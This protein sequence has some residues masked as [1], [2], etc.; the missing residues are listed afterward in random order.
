MRKPLGPGVIRADT[1]V[2]GQLH[3]ELHHAMAQIDDPRRRCSF[4]R[5]CAEKYIILHRPDL[6]QGLA[7][8]S[9]QPPSGT[10][11]GGRG[12]SQN[13]SPALTDEA[14]VSAGATERAHQATHP[15]GGQSRSDMSPNPQETTPAPSR[16]PV[17]PVSARSSPPALT[18]PRAVSAGGRGSAAL[19]GALGHTTPGLG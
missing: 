11:N 16:V 14:A 4:L 3:P 6:L 9:P 10:Y 1:L 13:S 8:H 7:T 18:T 15:G 2:D 19:A 17:S 5:I 12:K